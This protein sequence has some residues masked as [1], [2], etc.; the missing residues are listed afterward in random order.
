MEV[1]PNRVIEALSK[2]VAALTVEKAMLE[3]ALDDMTSRETGLL[4]R[5][6]EL[7]AQ[8]NNA[9]EVPGGGGKSA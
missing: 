1:D 4:E 8:V 5:I 7:E 9:T 6:T 3:V 2:K